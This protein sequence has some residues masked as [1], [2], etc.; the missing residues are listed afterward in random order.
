MTT[1]LEAAIARLKY[2]ARDEEIPAGSAAGAKLSEDVAAVLAALSSPPANDVREALDADVKALL[3]R[4]WAAAD[5]AGVSREA[6][7]FEWPECH[8]PKCQSSHGL[9]DVAMSY[10]K[11]AIM[12]EIEAELCYRVTSRPDDRAPETDTPERAAAFHL[13]I[14]LRN[15]NVRDEGTF[16]R[17]AER[18]VEAYPELVPVF[19]GREVRLRGTVTDAEVEAAARAYAGDEMSAAEWEWVKSQPH[20]VEP[21]LTGMRAALEAAQRARVAAENPTP[22]NHADGSMK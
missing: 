19:S 15:H 1:E 12:A 21:Y 11:R 5:N 22:T 4:L 17:A 16:I 18:I 13:A 14:L 2:V 20:L 6:V 10:M 8:K 3:G 7:E 9:P